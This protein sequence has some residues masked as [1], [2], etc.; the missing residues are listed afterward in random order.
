MSIA[1]LDVGTT[2]CKCTLYSENGEFLSES[3]LE[4]CQSQGSENTEIDGLAVWESVKRV[5]RDIATEAADLKAIGVTSFGE[6]VVLL[7][8]GDKPLMNS[9]LYTDTR[10]EEQ[11]ERLVQRF[12][13]KKLETITG[14]KPHCMYSISKL[15]WIRENKPEIYDAAKRI[16]LFEDYI[17]YM[18][19][20]M[21]QIDYSLATRTMAFD[22]SRLQWSDEILTFANIGKEKLADVVPTG[23]RAGYLKEDLA[24]LLGLPAN[25]VIVSGCH[26]QMAA[27]IGAGVLQP[28]MSVDGTGTVECITPVFHEIPSANI[29]F[30][31]GYSVTP[32]VTPGCYITYAFSFTGGALLKWYRD[33][34]NGKK[35]EIEQREGR[36]IYD[37]L[38]DKVK[39]KPSGLLVLPHF[40]GAATPYMD[41]HSTGAIV[42]L[43]LA[44]DAI[45]IYRALM[46]GVTFEMLLNMEHLRAAGIEIREIR[47]T[48]GGANSGLWLQMK[49]DILN[50]PVVSLGVAQ[51]GT[52]GCVML[53]GIACG[54]YQNLEEAVGIFVKD[55]ITYYPRKEKNKEYLKIYSKYKKLYSAIKEVVV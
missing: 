4:Y 27:T 38:N 25:V 39:D 23:S 45:D 7:D 54:M 30:E 55:G 24:H 1:G 16:L 29:F 10:G 48:G 12:G 52:M 47:A 22:I 18:L 41:S 19:S 44:T 40:S 35:E 20:G 8:A 43:T 17:V 51:A 53:A 15:M 13:E 28:G 46:E 6:S 50:I 42:G 37:V 26:D 36:S 21:A 2:G 14:L 31:S 11:C 34:L 49:A 3:Y 9:M 33:K 32:H 5:L